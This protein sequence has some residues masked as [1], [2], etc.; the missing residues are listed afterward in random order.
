MK[1]AQKKKKNRHFYDLSR[2]KSRHFNE[3]KLFVE[4]QATTG[5]FDVVG[6]FAF[7]LAKY[8]S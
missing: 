3:K 1:L 2:L 6:N 8:P 4:L 7:Y 5:H